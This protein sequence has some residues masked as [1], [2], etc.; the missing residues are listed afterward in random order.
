MLSVR[1]G[2]RARPLRARVPGASR[3]RRATITRGR[4]ARSTR[5]RARALA[6]RALSRALGRSA[7]AGAAR[8]RA[9][10]GRPH[11][12]A[13]RA[14]GLARRA[15]TR[16]SSFAAAREPAPARA[17]ASSCVLHDLDDVQR[18]CD[19]A[20]LLDRRPRPLRRA[21][22]AASR[23]H[24]PRPR[25]STACASSTRDRLGFRLRRALRRSVSDLDPRRRA[26]G[27]EPLR[28]SARALGLSPRAPVYVATSRVWDDDHRARIERHRRERGTE[29]HT[30]EARARPGGAAAR[31]RSGRDRL[32]HALALQLLRRL[33]TAMSRRCRRL[34]R[35][36][37]RSAR[38]APDATLARGLQRARAEPART[39]RAGPQVRRPAGPGEPVHRR[40]RRQ[41]AC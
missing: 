31:R 33:R 2:G 15:H 8:A 9:R 40:A 29:W 18:H 22:R 30:I 35:A 17:I 23:L 37:G 6:A 1:A 3:T 25:P 34:R 41:R 5:M 12:P 24:A 7:A 36:A 21:R 4:R 26:L 13:R 10:H 38:R 32:R 16:S 39:D 14:D 11:P 19:A 28:A 20:L 27:Q